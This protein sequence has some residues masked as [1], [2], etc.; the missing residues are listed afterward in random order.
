MVHNCAILDLQ[1]PAREK[2]RDLTQTYDNSPY[3][4][5]KIPK[6]TS[7]QKNIT[8][9][10]DYTMI[11]NQLRTVSWSNDSH[12]IGVVKPAYRIPTFLLTAKAV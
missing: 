6:A 3:T 2:G 1:T 8:N 9:N 10:F 4:H 12:P 11:A 7:Q 5:R